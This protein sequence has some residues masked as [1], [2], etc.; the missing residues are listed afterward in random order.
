MST[1]NAS[2]IDYELALRYIKSTM[3]RGFT[4]IELLVVITIIGILAAIALP[5]YMKAKDRAKEAESKANCHTIQIAL[6]RYAVD[7]GDVYPPWLIGGDSES[8]GMWHNAYDTGINP[9]DADNGMNRISYPDFCVDPLVSYCYINSYPR[10]PFIS[11]S[12]IIIESTYDDVTG[13]GDPRF[14]IAGDVI[15]QGLDDPM[16]YRWVSSWGQPCLK[17][18]D[19]SLTLPDA[20]E[21]GFA[22]WETEP[23]GLHYMFGGRRNPYGGEPLQAWWPGNFFYRAGWATSRN[24]EATGI[25]YPAHPAYRRGPYTYFLGVY[26]VVDGMD[27]IRLEST[28]TNGAE[29]FYRLPPPWNVDS[30][31]S[32]ATTIRLG[33]WVGNNEER[34]IPEVFGGYWRN[35]LGEGEK[36]AVPRPSWPYYD[37]SATQGY[38]WAYGCPDGVSDGVVLCLIPD[39]GFHPESQNWEIYF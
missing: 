10:N 25:G 38:T 23:P 18:M 12:K 29:M 32:G 21:L 28:Y 26:G 33:V 17:L 13:L 3:Q 34:G 24:Y 19:F 16:F 27:V 31:V 15:G 36:G 22:D 39:G 9:E 11:D 6:E 7:N 2:A 37:W 4:L 8:W 14:G 20:I 35:Y 30:A 5:N 1:G